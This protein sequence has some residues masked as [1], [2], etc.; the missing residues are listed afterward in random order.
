[1]L[2]SVIDRYKLGISEKSLF[3]HELPR[4]SQHPNFYLEFKPV[5]YRILRVALDLTNQVR[6]L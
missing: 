3:E 6:Y 2:V 4:N 5:Y 1:M